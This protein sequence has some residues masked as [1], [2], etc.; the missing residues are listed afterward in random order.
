[1]RI[2]FYELEEI[3]DSFLEFAV[4]F[5][6]FDGK[7]IFV[8]H[9]D[10]NTWEIPGGHREVDEK[11]EDTAKR[12]LKEETGVKDFHIF[13]VCDYSVDIDIERRYGRLFFCDVKEISDKL[14]YEIE[15]VGFFEECPTNLTYPEIQPY[16]H[17]EIK[18][19]WR[20][21]W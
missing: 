7:Y 8:R 3:E 20:L 2:D 21:L 19:R 10:R 4:I 11:I 6:V 16:L 14:E 18:K 13:P 5:S 1:M 12:E 9:R 15:E 17:E